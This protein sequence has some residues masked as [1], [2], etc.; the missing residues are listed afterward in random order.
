MVAAT[1]VGSRKRKR[2]VPP[3]FESFLT[4]PRDRVERSS[5][6]IPFPI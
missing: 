5:R 4:Q 3:R 1:I 6:N 2:M